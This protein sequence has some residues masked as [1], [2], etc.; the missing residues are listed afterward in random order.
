[1]EIGY[2]HHGDAQARIR[3]CPGLGAKLQASTRELC[4]LQVR[5]ERQ[6]QGHASALL[7]E[8]CDEADAAGVML[9]LFVEPFDAGLSADSLVAWYG[10]HGFAEIQAEPVKMMARQ[11]GATPR[12][13]SGKRVPSAQ[14]LEH[15]Q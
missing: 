14:P 9:V 13:L 8:V 10:R 11:I 12:I 6:G 2:R 1:M 5:E 15:S 3:L 4:D 7:R